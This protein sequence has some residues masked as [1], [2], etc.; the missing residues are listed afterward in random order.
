V[1]DLSA[2]GFGGLFLLLAGCQS[3]LAPP[4]NLDLVPV[5]YADL[6]GW[7]KDQTLKAVPALRRSCE[8][9][10]KKDSSTP[11]LTQGIQGTVQD[12][13]PFC[14]AVV[15]R[16]FQTES[17]VRD[18]IQDH[19][20]PYQASYSAT[21]TGLFTGYDEPELRGSTHRHGP[22]QTPLYRLPG[23]GISY[24]GMT[25]S[26]IVKGGLKG[27]GLELVWVDDPIDAFFLQI[28]GS[29]RVRL[30]NGDVL[31]LGYAGT[32][33]CPYLAIGKPLIERGAFSAEEVSRQT[34]RAWLKA[35]PRE[36]ESVMSL[37]KSYVF[38]RILT[39]EGPVG[40]QNVALTPQRSLA[41]DRD[42]IPLGTPLW[43]DL[44]HPNSGDQRIQSLV[45]AQD[46]GGAIK[47]GIRG[48]LFW[49]CGVE[50]ADLAGRMK[51]RG[52]YYLLLPK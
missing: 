39:G 48:D 4:S 28:Q 15:D 51:S 52:E 35:H 1:K 33:K 50:P 5:T 9:L 43:I 20:K 34:I 25:R 38:F 18:L 7:E 41:V 3:Q 36:A 6:P 16:A 8:V 45:I 24:K 40:S 17:A 22:Y 21:T 2:Y 10:L 12:W 49:G 47:G 46:T 11:M 31:R 30:E 37:N 14:T 29:G 44:D 42:Y 32:N 27:R 26:R 19:L 23:S 13:K